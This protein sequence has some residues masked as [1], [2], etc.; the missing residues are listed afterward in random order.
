MTIKKC[1][2]PGK[3]P[4]V[5]NRTQLQWQIFFLNIKFH[6]TET[7]RLLKKC[8][9]NKWTTSAV[10]FYAFGCHSTTGVENKQ[11][12]YS[13]MLIICI[14]YECKHEKKAQPMELALICDSLWS[15]KMKRRSKIPIYETHKWNSSNIKNKYKRNHYQ[16]NESLLCRNS[17]D[18]AEIECNHNGS[19]RHCVPKHA[20]DSLICM[21]CGQILCAVAIFVCLFY[22]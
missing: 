8:Q 14:Q 11:N 17:G 16:E 22:L 20:Q 12:I 21:I 7:A 1:P 3:W 19:H 9:Q 15:S 10:A 5:V 4:G 13:S 2:K 6:N 18:F